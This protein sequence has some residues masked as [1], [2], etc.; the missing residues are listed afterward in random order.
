MLHGTL[1]HSVFG[2][3]SSAHSQSPILLSAGYHAKSSPSV[4][5][6][7]EA[8]SVLEV[9]VGIICAC[10]LAL[11]AFL[12]RHWPQR[13]SSRL[14][15]KLESYFGS[16]ST[17]NSS[18]PTSKGDQSSSKETHNPPSSEERLRVTHPPEHGWT[19]LDTVESFEPLACPLNPTQTSVGRAMPD[20]DLENWGQSGILK[21]VE[22]TQSYPLVER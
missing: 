3:K 16:T 12:D 18:K 21:K 1:P 22:Y 13:A 9:D 15:S 20:E 8:I 14:L 4:M 17:S 7:D 11:P 10:S 19:R 6:T 5:Y 2:C